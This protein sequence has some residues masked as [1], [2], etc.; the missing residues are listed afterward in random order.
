M[1]TFIVDGARH[2]V[3]RATRITL[4]TRFPDD[5]D[6]RQPDRSRVRISQLFQSPDGRTDAG[7]T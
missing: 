1:A 6:A 2:L 7:T 4:Q 3:Q 5:D